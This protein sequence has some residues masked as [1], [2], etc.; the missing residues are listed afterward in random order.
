MSF[1]IPVQI[2][3]SRPHFFCPIALLHSYQAS[4]LQ[5]PLA[6][7]CVWP[8]SLVLC[9][10]Q[11]LAQVVCRVTETADPGHQ[12]A[13]HDL[14]SLGMCLDY[15]RHFS[16]K[17]THCA[18]PYLSHHVLDIQCVAMGSSPSVPCYFT[19]VERTQSQLWEGL[20]WPFIFLWH[21]VYPVYCTYNV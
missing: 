5:A 1:C 11:H 9:H 16:E 18:G 12:S 6:C 19:L 7:L 4:T 13:S 15:L 2:E 17:H 3:D 8:M 10:K 21:S 14:Q 20:S